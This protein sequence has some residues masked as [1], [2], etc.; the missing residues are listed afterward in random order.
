MNRYINDDAPVTPNI[1]KAKNISIDELRQ[2]LIEAYDAAP[3]T[4]MSGR[5][6]AQTTYPDDI[7]ALE[8][9]VAVVSLNPTYANKDL[10]NIHFNPNAHIIVDS[11]I[12]KTYMGDVG[13]SLI[14][15]HTLDNGFTFCGVVSGG[16]CEM[17]L[18]Y[19]LYYNDGNIRAYIP[20]KGNVVNCDTLTALGSEHNM[21]NSNTGRNSLELY[22]AYKK[23]GLLTP[24]NASIDDFFDA[25]QH[26]GMNSYLAQYDHLIIRG[27]VPNMALDP[28][29][30][31]FNWDAITEELKTSIE[32]V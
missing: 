20:I 5:T 10:S 27:A 18:F 2:K 22:D 7:A 6:Y 13:E 8:D 24:A 19:C 21:C 17:P 3:S 32:I 14:G 11:T 25:D 28:K 1:R 31:G 23:N 29:D 15:F 26:I 30:G 9:L 16:S 4:K 12:A